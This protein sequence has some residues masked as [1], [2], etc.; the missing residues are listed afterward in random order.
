MR[1]AIAVLRNGDRPEA[2]C[3]FLNVG[4]HMGQADILG[5]AIA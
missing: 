2:D 5:L 3:I 4:D 1:L